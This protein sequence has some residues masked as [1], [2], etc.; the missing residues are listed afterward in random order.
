[1]NTIKILVLFEDGFS[2]Y[3]LMLKNLDSIIHSS[4]YGKKNY[5]IEVHAPYSAESLSLYSEIVQHSEIY[6][7]DPIPIGVDSL[8][9]LFSLME[10]GSEYDAEFVKDYFSDIDYTLLFLNSQNVGRYESGIEWMR[11]MNNRFRYVNYSPK[12][13]ANI[14]HIQ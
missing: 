12:S 9:N 3:K 14:E 6:G 2:E 13:H 4:V 1:M 5:R 11:S 10:T 7:Y 8:S